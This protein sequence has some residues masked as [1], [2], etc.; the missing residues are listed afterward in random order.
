MLPAAASGWC[1]P[2]RSSAASHSTTLSSAGRC[3][4]NQSPTRPRAAQRTQARPSRD[5][6]S[7]TEA[8]AADALRAR[9]PAGR[10]P[11]ADTDHCERPQ[12]ESEWRVLTDAL[13][14][15]HADVLSGRRAQG[16]AGKNTRAHQH[17]RTQART[18]RA[19]THARASFFQ[20]S[21]TSCRPVAFVRC[22]QPPSPS[23]RTQLHAL[24]AATL[25]AAGLY[26]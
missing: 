2:T 6:H 18:A 15:R 21:H 10:E 13:R 1:G 3:G 14:T 5:A 17:T 16:A 26:R 22:F 24:L 12:C 7:S 23:G 25:P 9:A 4:R 20:G 8:H 19:H 11:E